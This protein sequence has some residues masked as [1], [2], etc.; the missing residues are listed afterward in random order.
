MKKQNTKNK[1]RV[2]IIILL[3]LLTIV[4]RIPALNLNN[5][6]YS[7]PDDNYIINPAVQIAENIKHNPK[8][9][10]LPDST[11]FYL[12]GLN[13]KTATTL[14]KS[15]GLKANIIIDYQAQSSWIYILAR[16]WNLIFTIGIVIISYLLTYRISRSDLAAIIAGLGIIFSSLL[17]EHTA[18]ARPDILL[19]FLSLIVLWYCLNIYQKG[20]LKDYLMLGGIWGLAVAT[21]YPGILLGVPLLL[22]H[23]SKQKGGKRI[24]I[25]KNIWL[26]ALLGIVVFFAV[27]PH[28]LFSLPEVKNDILYEAT[29]EHGAA[30]ASP[31]NNIWFYLRTSFNYGIG[32]LFTILAGLTILLSLIKRDKI[33]PRTQNLIIL[34]Y[35]LLF[36]LGLCW[37]KLHWD[38][39]MIPILSLIALYAGCGIQKMW[40]Y[41]N[42]RNN[43]IFKQKKTMLALIIVIIMLPVIIRGGKT[44]YAFTKPDTKT[45]ATTWINENIE[46]G[47]AIYR[48]HHAPRIDADKFQVTTQFFLF[49]HPYTDHASRGA[50]YLVINHNFTEQAIDY[51][52]RKPH[53]REN[54]EQLLNDISPQK[55]LP[56]SADQSF[57]QQIHASDWQ[58]FKKM[59]DLQ[60]WKGDRIGVYEL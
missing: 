58:I 41:F 44:S 46:D 14:M 18:Y 2:K 53:F 1:H 20:G 27:T 17:I 5:Q 15:S 36:W 10:G 45:T 42:Q 56:G 59:L 54:Y 28:F 19:G 12:L 22:A 47:K 25:N 60:I 39:W 7:H 49:E 24:I 26:C 11:L 37:H 38:R 31:I 4:T 52:E 43:Q 6:H 55:L 16:I 3:A 13:Y 48:D 35:P 40:D 30:E 21:K 57:T 32:T 51:E 29:R 33:I 34:S 23:I 8:Q 50:Q 9:F